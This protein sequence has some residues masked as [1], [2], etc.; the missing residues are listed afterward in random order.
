MGCFRATLKH[1]QA[2]YTR[3]SYKYKAVPNNSTLHQRSTTLKYVSSNEFA[4]INWRWYFERLQ[5]F[6]N[7]SDF[8]FFKP[9]LKYLNTK[10]TSEIIETRNN[11]LERI[12]VYRSKGYAIFYQHETYV[13]KTMAPFKLLQVDSRY[14]CSE[15]LDKITT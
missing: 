4:N 14:R 6:M 3:L 8:S 1:F 9:A 2:A 12:E 7:G 10:E 13:Y 15:I 11:S 5:C